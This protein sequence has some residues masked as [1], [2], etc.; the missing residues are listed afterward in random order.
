MVLAGCVCSL[1]ALN[2]AKLMLPASML[3]RRGGVLVHTLQKGLLLS[4]SARGWSFLSS[5]QVLLSCAR[6]FQVSF[7]ASASVVV[8]S[9]PGRA[10]LGCKRQDAPTAPLCAAAVRLPGAG[11]GGVPAD[12]LHRVSQ[13]CCISCK[14][15]NFAY[16]NCSQIRS[17]P[18]LPSPKVMSSMWKDPKITC[19]LGWFWYFRMHIVLG[20]SVI[21]RARNV[22]KRKDVFVCVGGRVI[23]S[24]LRP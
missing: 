5:F 22:I 18:L 20:Q 17:L 3:R 12:G 6:C 11:A 13:S 1:G 23:F 4:N 2:S 16:Q 15:V 21:S 8:F 14:V 19:I 7:A 9:S 10:V 24:S